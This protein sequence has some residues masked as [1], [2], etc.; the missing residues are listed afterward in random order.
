MQ[1]NLRRT[2]RGGR[3]IHKIQVHLRIKMKIELFAHAPTELEIKAM[4]L[5]AGKG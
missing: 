2:S 1:V 5:L 4:K 3:N